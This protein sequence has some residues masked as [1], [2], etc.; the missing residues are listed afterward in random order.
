MARLLRVTP[1]GIPL[2]IIQ[3]GVNRQNCFILENDYYAYIR[4]L[5]EYSIKFKVHIHAWVLMTNHVHLLCTP[6]L[7]GSVSSMMQSLGRQYVR[8]FNHKNS[9]T[10]TLWE[11]RFKSC[12]VET[13]RYLFQLYKYIELNPVRAGLAKSPEAY[14]WSSYHMNALGLYSDL[15]NP[16]Y[17]YLS[18]DSNPEKRREAYRMLFKEDLEQS[19][20]DEI[21]KSINQGTA[22]GSKNFKNNT[23]IMTGINLDRDRRHYK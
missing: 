11:G 7:N 18:L 10:G 21:R 19:N 15:C 4:W 6:M 8:Y 1:R 22:V 5:K 23:K 3:R 12:L 2:H 14:K 17:L 13:D 16:H 9:R 20:I